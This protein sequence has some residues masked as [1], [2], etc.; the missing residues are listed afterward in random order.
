M[1]LASEGQGGRDEKFLGVG[2]VQFGSCPVSGTSP[3]PTQGH[4]YLTPA[5]RWSHGPLLTSPDKG[6]L[7][8][9]SLTIVLLA[10]LFHVNLQLPFGGLAVGIT[11][12]RGG[13]STD[14]T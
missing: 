2:S 6:T 1:P 11:I 7:T 13:E 5:P 9:L 12:C 14:K 8:G 10:V 4:L 3:T